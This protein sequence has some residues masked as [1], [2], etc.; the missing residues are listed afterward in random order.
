MI[1]QN[2]LPDPLHI[3]LL[4]TSELGKDYLENKEHYDSLADHVVYTGPIDAYYGWQFGKLEYRSLRFETEI[5]A[6]ENHQGVAVVNYKMCIRDR[7]KRLRK[8]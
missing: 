6:E 7:P 8:N 4:Y 1:L 5:L 3:C 2:G